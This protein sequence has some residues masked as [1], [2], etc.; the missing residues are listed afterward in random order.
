M[1]SKT[2]TTTARKKS[3]TTTAT[4]KTA[5]KRAR[6]APKVPAMPVEEEGNEAEEEITTVDDE[7]EEEEVNEEGGGAEEGTEATEDAAE[8]KIEQRLDDT[9]QELKDYK[10]MVRGMCNA[11]IDQLQ[12]AKREIRQLRRTQKKPRQQKDSKVPKKKSTFEIPI[13]ISDELCDFLE[14]PHGSKMSR[15]Q[16]THNIQ[17]Y[18]SSNG[19]MEGR[20]IK[21]DRKMKKI[22]QGVPKNKTFELTWLNLQSYIKHHYI[23]APDEEDEE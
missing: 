22:L 7:E 19:L 23:S 16:V 2:K 4:K 17:K 18:C 15:N 8:K 5:V 20:V 1:S 13:T 10:A 9:I 12:D 3:A 14:K 11:F 21:P 6:K